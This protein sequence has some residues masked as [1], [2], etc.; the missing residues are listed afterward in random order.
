MTDKRMLV[1]KVSDAHAT[2]MVV[3]W[4]AKGYRE[5][6][7]AFFRNHRDVMVR[8]L[9]NRVGPYALVKVTKVKFH[10]DR[11]VSEVVAMTVDMEVYH[12]VR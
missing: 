8:D 4:Q 3:L 11:W 6:V 2:R 5:G 10:R 9:R 1:E 7:L 12:A